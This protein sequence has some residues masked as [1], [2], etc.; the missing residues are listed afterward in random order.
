MEAH[1]PEYVRYVGQVLQKIVL[2]TREVAIE[3]CEGG[4][5]EKCGDQF[6]IKNIS[7]SSEAQKLPCSTQI[8]IHLSFFHVFLMSRVM[9][10][11]KSYRS[12]AVEMNSLHHG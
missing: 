11:C 12:L 5:E 2:L 8:Q 9:H 1:F 3:R 10:I 6:V 7:I 4:Q